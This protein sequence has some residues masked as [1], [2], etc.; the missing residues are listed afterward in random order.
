MLRARE[1]EVRIDGKGEVKVKR[2]LTTG[3]THGYGG[4]KE[5][6]VATALGK[7]RSIIG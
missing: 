1:L 7:R 3:G 2:L 6:E 4:T 5:L